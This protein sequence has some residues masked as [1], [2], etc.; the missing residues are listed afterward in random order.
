[1]GAIQR[2]GRHARISPLRSRVPDAQDHS[3]D[4][5]IDSLLKAAQYDSDIKKTPSTYYS[6][7]S[8]RIG[9]LQ[10]ALGGISD[11]IRR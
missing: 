5:A 9:S 10:D 1:M 6:R 7:R 11:P 3:P 4:Q 2:Q 8:L